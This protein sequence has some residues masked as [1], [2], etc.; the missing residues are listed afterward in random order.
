MTAA[1]AN[2]TLGLLSQLGVEDRKIQQIAEIMSAFETRAAE[3][4]ELERL[5]VENEH[6]KALNR[7]LLAH[8]DFL[9]S[10]VGAC[11][12]CW[13]EDAEC[14]QCGG[15]G[16]PGAFVPQRVSFD[17][18]VRP[19]LNRVRQRLA[20]QRRRATPAPRPVPESTFEPAS[21]PVDK[22]N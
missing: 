15:C 7:T 20:A 1:A 4:E 3:A 21:E 9:A 10:A 2:P 13:G 14:P 6:L 16:G 22:E 8:S 19:V 11:P 18:I 5:R 12:E 17:E